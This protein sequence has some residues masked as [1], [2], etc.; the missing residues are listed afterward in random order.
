MK[1]IGLTGGIASGK[2]TVARWIEVRGVPVLD[3]D[4][5]SRDVTRPGMEALQKIVERWPQTLLGDGTLD[6]TTLG[7]IA[8]SQPTER[9]SLEAI[10]LP[11]I[12]KAFE[13][14]ASACEAAGCPIC[15]FDAALLFEHNLDARFDGI[16]LVA[17][18]PELQI[19]R[20][21]ARDGL[22]CSQARARLSAQLPLETKRARARWI[23]ENEGSI[24][25][26][27]THFETLWAT[28]S[29]DM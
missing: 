23:L 14:W 17:A 19:E 18:P 1:R 15:V 2:S 22:S 20:L 28:L 5:V 21:M 29:A 24:G 10:V 16:L 11:E 8:F 26:L 4:Q 12:L 25:E 27:R 13:N 9:Q 6:R 7:R 3:A